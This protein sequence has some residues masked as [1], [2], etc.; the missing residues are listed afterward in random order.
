MSYRR[1]D[2]AEIGEGLATVATIATL[3][4]AKERTVASVATVAR[5]EPKSSIAAPIPVGDVL[6]AHE[7]AIARLL[8]TGTPISEV[9]GQALAIV[10]AELRNDARLSEKQADPF[11]CFVCHDPAKPDRP[12]A[13]FLSPIK[14]EHHWLHLDCH[15]EHCRRQA[16]KADACL[17]ETGT[18]RSD[19]GAPIG[20]PA[21]SYSRES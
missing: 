11:R 10:R 12:L 20:L 5:E 18:S 7:R 15:A 21:P 14:G 1:F 6:L 17:A 9:S 19:G 16:A 8:A 2:F 3:E 13:A 4:P